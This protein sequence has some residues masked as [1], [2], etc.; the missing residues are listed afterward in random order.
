MKLL[1]MHSPQFR[2]YLVSLRKKYLRQHPYFEHREAISS[3]NV[4]DQALH[5]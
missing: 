5:P 2:S 1:I 4:R 3:F